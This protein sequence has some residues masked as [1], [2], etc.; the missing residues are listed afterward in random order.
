MEPL[1]WLKEVELLFR[2]NLGPTFKTP[3]EH[4]LLCN[5]TGKS[6]YWFRRLANMTMLLF[7]ERW[8][9]HK[10]QR[11]FLLFLHIPIDSVSY[12]KWAYRQLYVRKTLNFN[13]LI[14]RIRIYFVLERVTLEYFR[15]G[16]RYICDY[17]VSCYSILR[18]IKYTDSI[19]YPW[20]IAE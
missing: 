8:F 14:K 1:I 13:N 19:K 20:W 5:L 18:T 10:S 9:L 16:K 17:G 4:T 7:N 11:T 3:L 6:D 12:L 15:E 2:W